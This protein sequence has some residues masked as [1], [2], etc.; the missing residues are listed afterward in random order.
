MSDEEL[1]ELWVRTHQNMSALNFF[2]GTIGPVNGE[3][4]DVD[5][6]K[7]PLRYR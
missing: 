6:T 3:V 5:K 7:M 1:L 2:P 4:L